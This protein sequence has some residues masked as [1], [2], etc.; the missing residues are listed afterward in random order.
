MKQM[1]N[2]WLNNIKT[3]D[4][5]VVHLEN[6]LSILKENANFADFADNEVKE[7]YKKDITYMKQFFE[8]AEFIIRN[9]K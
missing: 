3:V 1:P 6:F 7:Q 8:R 5:V 9:K 4:D 2:I